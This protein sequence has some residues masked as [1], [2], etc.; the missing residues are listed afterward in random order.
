MESELTQPLLHEMTMTLRAAGRDDL[1]DALRN[2]TA[3]K[4]RDLRS[5]EVA[6]LLG[7]SSVNTVKNWLEGGD[8]PGAYRT[9]G[10]QWRFPKDEVLALKKR[11]EDLRSK[12][13]RREMTPEDEGSE[14]EPPLL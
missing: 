9:R 10:G 7:V 3:E 4:S 6:E 5:G 14:L 8:F 12:N 2:A 1:A 13:L 11:M